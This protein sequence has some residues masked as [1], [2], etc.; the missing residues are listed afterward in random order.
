MKDKRSIMIGSLI[1][2]AILLLI[3]FQQMLAMDEPEYL[4]FE[5]QS[6]SWKVVIE[7]QQSKR[8]FHQY[9]VSERYELNYIGD[10]IEGVVRDY[11]VEWR[12]QSVLSSNESSNTASDFSEF[13]G[14]AEGGVTIETNASSQVADVDD[15]FQV[16][17]AWNGGMNEQV[18]LTCVAWK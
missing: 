17:I 11:P 4:V 12:V 10:P 16:D 7:V 14:T 2:V 5:G 6:D 1:I 15:V 3:P 18:S 9:V 13:L 8:Y